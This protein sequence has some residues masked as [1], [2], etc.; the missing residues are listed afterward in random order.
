MT[1]FFFFF[2]KTK[3]INQCK[4]KTNPGGHRTNS[5]RTEAELEKRIGNLLLIDK[6]EFIDGIYRDLID[7]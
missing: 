2:R 5:N 1:D 7:H 4:V 6:I 3:E